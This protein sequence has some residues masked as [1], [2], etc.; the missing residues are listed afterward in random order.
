MS[1]QRE[2]GLKFEK[3]NGY[4]QKGK[5]YLDAIEWVIISDMMTR[6]AAFKRGEVNVLLIVEPPD[7]KELEKEGKY[8]FS[9]GGLSGINICLAGDSGHPNSPFSDIRVR[10]AVEHAVE[11]QALVDA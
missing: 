11:K 3:F 1:W 9:T 4:W 7:V 10:R 2:S 6:T 8:Y 5:P